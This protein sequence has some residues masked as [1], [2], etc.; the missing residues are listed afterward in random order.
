[1]KE[2][3]GEGSGG[4]ESYVSHHT[5]TSGRRNDEEIRDERSRRK[6]RVVAP[7]VRLRGN[8]DGGIWI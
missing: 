2:S 5:K 1:M 4:V 7:V 8:H 6:G 3:S